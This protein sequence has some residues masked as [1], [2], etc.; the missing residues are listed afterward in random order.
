MLRRAEALALANSLRGVLPAVLP[1][2]VRPED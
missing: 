2:R 1:A